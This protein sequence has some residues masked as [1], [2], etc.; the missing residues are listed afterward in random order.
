M[1][2]DLTDLMKTEI[3]PL[4]LPVL[5]E[6]CVMP[7]LVSTNFSKQAA[8]QNDKI[9]IPKAQNLGA[10]GD[11]D[12]SSGSSSTD[13]G[14][15]K[16]DITLSQWKYKQ[17]Q[18]SD[19]EM[20]ESVTAGILPSAVDSSVRALANAIDADLL[21]LYKDIPY[22]HGTAGTTPDAKED[23]TGVRKVLQK[24]LAPNEMRRLLLDVEAED[25]LLQ[26]FSDAEKVGSTEALRN[27]CLGRLFGF[28][29][30]SDQLIQEHT[31]GTFAAGSPVVNGAVSAG[32]T[33]MAIDGGS[34]SETIKAGDAFTV[35]GVDGQF[36]FTADATASTGA[37]AS[38]SFYP[39]A[40]T[41]GFADNAVI[42]ILDDHT[43]SL[44]FHRDAFALAVRPLGD[45]GQSE[46]SSIAIEVDPLSGLPLRME[47]WRSPGNATR[48]WRFDI[49]YGVKTLQ[50]ELAAR[51]LG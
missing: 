4:A 32:A 15:E 19:K 5:R 38:A 20:M 1:A 36:V 35:A 29:T 24:N 27:A 51:L 10:A 16:V 25:K 42:T 8:E 45:G 22:Y 23:V 49:L 12:P 11:F 47:T 14:D 18:M 34:A 28:E 21:A 13:L 33:S 30:Y 3:M 6:A 44:A 41:G 26:V 17:F 50:P 7:A 48:Y 43:P 46:S 40:P 31:A 37:I 2:N 9:R 39:A